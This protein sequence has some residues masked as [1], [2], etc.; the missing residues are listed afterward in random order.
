VHATVLYLCAS[1]RFTNLSCACELHHSAVV[2]SMVGCVQELRR[3]LIPLMFLP[4][5]C[6]GRMSLTQTLMT[7]SMRGTQATLGQLSS[8][9]CPP[10]LP[11]SLH[12]TGCRRHTLGM[13]DS[14][15]CSQ[16]VTA[17]AGLPAVLI[18]I[19][20]DPCLTSMPSIA[21]PAVLPAAGTCT[22]GQQSC[23]GPAHALWRWP[24]P[25]VSLTPSC[26]PACRS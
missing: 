14:P 11:H 21:C 24:S 4:A 7:R 2:T 18:H 25:Q 8:E 1:W 16:H 19:A 9:C 5:V 20:Y 15:S 23:S 22:T 3:T 13:P 6:T 26:T 10:G 12:D 17:A